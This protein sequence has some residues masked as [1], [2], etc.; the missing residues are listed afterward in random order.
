MTFFFWHPLIIRNWMSGQPNVTPGDQY[1]PAH[2]LIIFWACHMT[3]G[4]LSSAD[5]MDH[6]WTCYS[7]LL[8]RLKCC[9]LILKNCLELS[10]NGIHLSQLQRS[11]P[12]VFMQTHLPWMCGQ[13]WR[14]VA[15]LANVI[16][17]PG[18]L[19]LFFLFELPGRF[20][21]FVCQYNWFTGPGT[22]VLSQGHTNLDLSC[23]LP[24]S[25]S[26]QHPPSSKAS[27][28][29]PLASQRS[30]TFARESPWKCAQRTEEAHTAASV[31][32]SGRWRTFS[33]QV[34]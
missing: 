8:C 17:A 11:W 28:P 26:E 27:S 9:F 29:K 6:L 16:L 7:L 2:I 4:K 19:F 24:S 5:I 30:H 15:C 13:D 31:S 14:Q 34:L 10:V 20:L 12:S 32:T 3:L 23:L 18:V 21:L 33:F 22:V 25:Q 1:V